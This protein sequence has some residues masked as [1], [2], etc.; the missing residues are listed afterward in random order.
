MRDVVYMIAKLLAINNVDA[1]Y[2]FDNDWKWIVTD[3]FFIGEL[4]SS[5]S[6]PQNISIIC[7]QDGVHMITS[8]DVIDDVDVVVDEEERPRLYVATKAGNYFE[9]GLTKEDKDEGAE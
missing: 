7:E 8:S 2:D 4:H 3:T 6:L 9:F 1:T 5:D